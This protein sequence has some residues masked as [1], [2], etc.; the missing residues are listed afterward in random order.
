MSVFF[1]YFLFFFF[2][3]FCRIADSDSDRIADSD[4]DFVMDAVSGE[5]SDNCVY[6]YFINSLVFVYNFYCNSESQFVDNFK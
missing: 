3:F 2:F 4:S 5:D 6:Y 1:F